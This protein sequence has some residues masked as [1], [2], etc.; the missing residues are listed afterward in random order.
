MEISFENK[1][2]EFKE[3][4]GQLSSD[5]LLEVR[6]LLDEY[7][8]KSE[9]SFAKQKSLRDLLSNG[10]TLSKGE[11]GKIQKARR[12]HNRTVLTSGF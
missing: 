3:M 11:L 6:K 8:E 1:L 5:E 2:E 10:P 9:P 12:I 4:L 7:A